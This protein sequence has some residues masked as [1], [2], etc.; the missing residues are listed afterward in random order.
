MKFSVI[1]NPLVLSD[2]KRNLILSLRTHH[3][4]VLLICPI[5][6]QCKSAAT[7]LS[8]LAKLPVLFDKYLQLRPLCDELLK[9][10]ETYFEN[11]GQ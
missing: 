3:R 2:G 1:F 6:S 10:K 4:L 5:L 9:L 7:S 8:V 11:F